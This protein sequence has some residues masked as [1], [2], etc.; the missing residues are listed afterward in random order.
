M[1]V[2]RSEH[3]EGSSWEWKR[4]KVGEDVGVIGVG[5]G[6]GAASVFTDDSVDSIVGEFVGLEIGA[7]LR[8]F[9]DAIVGNI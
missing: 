6:D 4:I 5:D 9:V 3:W 1:W 8:D 2:C 7:K